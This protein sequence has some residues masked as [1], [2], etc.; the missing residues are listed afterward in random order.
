VS[1]MASG[2][3][4]ARRLLASTDHAPQQSMPKLTR[5]DGGTN[6]LPHRT[7]PPLEF[8]MPETDFATALLETEVVV[9]HIGDD[10]VFH[11]PILSNGTVSLHGARMEPNPDAKREARRYLFDAHNAARAA[12]GRSFV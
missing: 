12:V 7:G 8:L 9:T 11:F 5:K 4:Q 10:H 3:H 2:D 1:H 6:P